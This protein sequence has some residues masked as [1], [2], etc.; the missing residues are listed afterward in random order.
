MSVDR[1]YRRVPKRAPLQCFPSGILRFCLHYTVRVLKSVDSYLAWLNEG[2]EIVTA[3]H[4]LARRIRREFDLARSDS[5]QTCWAAA[6]I[7]PWDAWLRHQWYCSLRGGGAADGQRILD[8]V[9]AQLVWRDIVSHSG[10]LDAHVNV[11]GV[12]KQAEAAYS[13]MHRYR[14]PF[15]MLGAS[16]RSPDHRAFAAWVA[17][18]R[19]RC[20]SQN[21]CDVHGLAAFVGAELGDS[22]LGIDKPVGFAGFDAALPDLDHLIERINACRL[23]AR[24]LDADRHEPD[25]QI[26]SCVD[27]VDE[28]LAAATWA[29]NCYL[30]NPGARIGVV[31]P[32]LAER[33]PEVRR[34]F[35]DVL[36]PGWRLADSDQPFDISYGTRLDTAGVVHTALLIMDFAGG[37][38]GYREAGQLLRSPYMPGWSNEASARCQLDIAMRR[39]PGENVSLH[40]VSRLA[41][42]LP[43]LSACFSVIGEY[44]LP[45]LATPAQWRLNLGQLLEQVG[46]PGERDLCEGDRQALRAWLECLD[47]FATLDAFTGP[48][49][50]HDA[51]RILRAV[52]GE[53][54][55]QEPGPGSGPQVMGVLE[56]IGIEFDHLWVSGLNADSWPGTTLPQP[57]IPL[58]LRKRFEFPDAT[59]ARSLQVARSRLKQLAHSAPNVVLSYCR[60]S[61]DELTMP[62]PLLYEFG[63][64]SSEP[65]NM[66]VPEQQL[67]Y[68]RC[69]LGAGPMEPMIHDTPAK[70][71]DTR[72]IAG[73]ARLVGLQAECP[74][75]AFFEFRLGARE[76]ETPPLIL[77]ARLRGMV[78]HDIMQRLV[79]PWLGCDWPREE[80]GPDLYDELERLATAVLRRRV[81]A[82]DRW[83]KQ[84]LGVE[85]RRQVQIIGELLGL[86]SRRPPFRVAKVEASEE[87]DFA[88]ITLTMRYDRV[89]LLENGAVLVIDYKTGGVSPAHWSGSRPRAPQLPMYALA[90]AASAIAYLRIDEGQVALVGMGSEDF[91]IRGM[92][93]VSAVTR[94]AVPD[95]NTQMEAWR[96]NIERLGQEFVAGDIRLPA[97]TGSQDRAG[98]QFAPLTRLF[99]P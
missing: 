16:A 10:H 64:D 88:G 65:C 82:P 27:S 40:A 8:K 83:Q 21:Y 52:V 32:G 79:E 90:S 91:G 15:D 39:Q 17:T 75:R 45:D 76:I 63:G 51:G 7:L 57:F 44:E 56:A 92:K 81:P 12:A 67:V 78:T 28:T 3:T 73:G 26:Q 60:Q 70:L 89:D 38:L 13:A 31:V 20:E 36:Q 53:R 41:E 30:Q 66:P 55:I 25:C 72:R 85:L 2:G 18:Y 69:L 71:A 87:F 43:V 50:L 93:S 46:W 47:R 34:V 1:L 77:D 35:R 68:D 14:V 48:L 42:A 84:I 29:R 37:R 11:V 24:R 9:Q 33:A 97:A 98:G 23:T 49:T 61:G 86:E 99:G 96:E 95:W 54:L 59:P 74:A 5:G 58:E 62:T 94:N 19:R 22:R 80:P 6:R 4:R